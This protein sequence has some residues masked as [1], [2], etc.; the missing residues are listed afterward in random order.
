MGLLSRGIDVSLI[1]CTFK[2]CGKY[3]GQIELSTVNSCPGKRGAAKISAAKVARLHIR[4]D[5][6]AS[7]KVSVAKV[8]ANETFG[9]IRASQVRAAKVHL[10][11]IKILAPEDTSP[12][13]VSLKDLITQGHTT[14]IWGSS[15]GLRPERLTIS[16]E[17]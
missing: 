3:P 2:I 4:A 9:E 14:L 6:A 8:R 13:C 16:G 15:S 12:T 11:R 17:K 1:G 10:F 7:F 5:E